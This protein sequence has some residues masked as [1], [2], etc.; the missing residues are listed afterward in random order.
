MYGDEAAKII[1]E[2]VAN[3]IKK[4]GISPKLAVILVG[5]DPA[6]Q[7]YVK[8]KERDLAECGI[9]SETIR[10]P[11]N[12]L[13]NDVCDIIDEL[14]MDPTVH[15]ILV[16]LPLPEHMNANQVIQHIHWT[17]DVD[18]LTIPNIGRFYAGNPYTVPCTAI[19]CMDI[20]KHYNIEI[21]GKRAV[22]IGR[23]AIVGQPLAQMLINA[24]ATVTICHSRTPQPILQDVCLKAD[25]ICSAVGKSN[26]VT[27][28][29]VKPGATLIDI[30][31]NRGADGKLCG[32]VDRACY[33]FAGSYT[34]VPKGIGKMTTAELCANVLTCARDKMI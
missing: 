16:Q 7:V 2:R 9:L 6:S 22:V 23:S 3:E 33:E 8:N 34:P 25:I 1:K 30:G 21:S 28:S 15:G 19:G 27:N 31:I 14:N 10:V 26:F 32:D 13:Q 4:I 5:D 11:G 17:K 20:M 29:I 18:C 24:N 12:V